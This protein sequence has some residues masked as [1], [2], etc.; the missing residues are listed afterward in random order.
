MGSMRGWRMLSFNIFPPGH[1][2]HPV[3]YRIHL[4]VC[5]IRPNS[6]KHNLRNCVR[7]IWG[8]VRIT[9]RSPIRACFTGD[10]CS[11]WGVVDPFHALLVR[12]KI[13]EPPAYITYPP[14]RSAHNEWGPAS[15]KALHIPAMNACS[16]LRGLNY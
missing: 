15:C 3:E 9:S 10:S 11:Y 1:K 14:P 8:A 6:V 13:V 4:S 2:Q 5:V 12:L 16:V 7:E